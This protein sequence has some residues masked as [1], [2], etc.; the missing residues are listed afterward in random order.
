MLDYENVEKEPPYPTIFP[1]V[2]HIKE[3]KTIIHTMFSTVLEYCGK[4]RKTLEDKTMFS[5]TGIGKTM[6]T[7][8]KTLSTKFSTFP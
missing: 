5:T 6:K 3:G 1:S 8:E 4:T 2:F 7:M